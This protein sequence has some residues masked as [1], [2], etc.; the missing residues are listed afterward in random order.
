MRQLVD[1]HYLKAECI[2]VVLNNLSP[3]NPDKFCEHLPP[4]ETRRLLDTLEFHFTPVH[5][6]WSNMAEIEFN[7]LKEQC[8]DRRIGD[9]DTLRTE[10]DAWIATRMTTNRT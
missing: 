1:E 3:H 6:S 7:R 9:E 5:G 10:I 2:R 4:T 8:L